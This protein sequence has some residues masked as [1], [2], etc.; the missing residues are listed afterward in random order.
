[1][2]SLTLLLIPLL[3][4]SSCAIDWNDEKDKKIAELEKQI[5]DDSFKKKQECSKYIPILENKIKEKE[6]NLNVDG[7]FY[8][9]TINEVFYSPIKQ[10]CIRL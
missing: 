1:M 6:K 3:L 7:V 2:K 10:T 4:L 5:Q 8:N 9:E